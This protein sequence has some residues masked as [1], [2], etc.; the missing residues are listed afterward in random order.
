MRWNH[1][2]VPPLLPCFGKTVLS[3]GVIFWG[4]RPPVLQMGPLLFHQDWTWQIEMLLNFEQIS[5]RWF[6]GQ[7]PT[8]D[9]RLGVGAKIS[10]SPVQPD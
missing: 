5:E 1:R 9:C 6:I 10:P 8:P 2:M 3:G 4:E 7:A